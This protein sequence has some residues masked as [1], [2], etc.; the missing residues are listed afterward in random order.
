MNRIVTWHIPYPGAPLERFY[1]ERDYTPEK[2]RILAE[3]APSVDCE[4]DIRDDG[5]TIFADRG[6][7]PTSKSA[8]RSTGTTKTTAVLPKGQTLEEA[9]DDFPTNGTTIAAGSVLTC[10][11]IEMGGAG[12]VTIQLELESLE[13]EDEEHEDTS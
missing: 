1:M 2:L 4:V 7:R 5:T 9:A 11:E 13:D 3:Q 10:H 6:L 12:N 8:S